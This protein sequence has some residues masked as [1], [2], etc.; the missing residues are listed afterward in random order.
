[1]GPIDRWFWNHP[2]AYVPIGVAFVALGIFLG[3]PIVV[4][5]GAVIIVFGLV[6]AIL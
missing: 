3:Q 4:G 5:V 2:L 1:M 6:R